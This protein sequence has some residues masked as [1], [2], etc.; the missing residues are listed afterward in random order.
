MAA[1]SSHP[2]AKEPHLVDTDPIPTSHGRRRAAGDV[3]VSTTNSFRKTI[4]I[5][6][7]E[8]TGGARDASAV[9]EATLDTWYQVATRLEPVIG[10][11]GV[12]V[13]FRRSLHL[14]C[15]A[16]PWLEIV[17]D[18][19]DSSALLASLKARLA[20]R[21]PDAAAEAGYTLLVTFIELLAT[22]IGESLTQRLLGPV[23]ELSLPKS[24]QENES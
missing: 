8:R 3:L 7:A 6:L 2:A 23:W 17:E 15:N 1:V 12:D 4:R 14:T 20:S 21:E 22:L 24:E 10:A 13:L 11:R 19:G 18:H 9:A 5:T 16:L